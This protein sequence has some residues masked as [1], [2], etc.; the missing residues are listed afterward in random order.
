MSLLVITIN[1]PSLDRK[2]AEVAYALYAANVALMEF[3]RGNGTKTSGTIL[4][5][6][7]TFSAT[8]P[9]AM[10]TWSYTATATNP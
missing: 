7:P 8:G 10:G 5:T 6:G 1:D 2:S 3:A 9:T 4:G